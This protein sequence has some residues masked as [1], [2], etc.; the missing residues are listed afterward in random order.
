MS[1]ATTDV[2]Y[3]DMLSSMEDSLH[4]DAENG[5]ISTFHGSGS[6]LDAVGQLTP[7]SETVAEEN[8]DSAESK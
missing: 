2:S 6:L 8:Q 3:A 4:L 1:E 7:V 5:I